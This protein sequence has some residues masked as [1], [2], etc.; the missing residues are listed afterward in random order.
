MN[1]GWE[2][3]NEQVQDIRS[4]EQSVNDLNKLCLRVFTTEDG[5]K[6]LEWLKNTYVEIPIAIP[7]TDPAHAFFNEGSRTVVR[8]IVWKMNKAKNL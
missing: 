4:A 3:L 8:D 7:G 2:G 5:A 1:D 6:F